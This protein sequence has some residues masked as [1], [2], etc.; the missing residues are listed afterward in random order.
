MKTDQSKIKKTKPQ[1]ATQQLRLTRLILEVEE[2]IHT[3]LLIAH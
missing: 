1:I 2:L 3:L